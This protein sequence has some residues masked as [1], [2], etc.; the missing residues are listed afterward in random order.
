M[1][2]ASLADRIEA[3]QAEGVA[4]KASLPVAGCELL[5]RLLERY[6]TRELAREAGVSPG[7]IS[8]V[9]AG[10]IVISPGAYVVLDEIERG[11][12]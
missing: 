5:R 10:K 12:E 2:K 7:Y 3:W 9:H 1:A 8:G 6:G 4:I 11:V